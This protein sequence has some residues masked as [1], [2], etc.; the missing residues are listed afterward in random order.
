MSVENRKSSPPRAFTAHAAMSGIPLEFCHGGGA[1]ITR[2]I[3]Y[4]MVEKLWRYVHSFTCHTTTRWTDQSTD[5][6]N[7]QKICAA[8]SGAGTI[9][10][11]PLQVV[12]SAWRS[13]RMLVMRVIVLH[14]C[15]KFEVR[16]SSSSEDMD[17][18]RSRR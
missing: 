3:P 15:T 11:R 18:F 14:P 13:P 6:H 9:C 4:Q 17:D 1:Q 5:R 16:R 7:G 12:L 10:P 2:M 8:S